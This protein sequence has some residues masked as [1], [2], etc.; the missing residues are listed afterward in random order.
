MRSLVL[1]L[2]SSRLAWGQALSTCPESI[3]TLKPTSF[4]RHR[5]LAGVFG[6][7]AL[8]AVFSL[9]STSTPAHAL[10]EA[11]PVF[12][13]AYPDAPACAAGAVACTMC[14]T[15]PPARNL[16][17]QAVEAE[18]LVGVPRPLDPDDFLAALPSAL[19]AI[20]A[21]DTDGDGSLNLEEILGGSAP[22]DDTSVPVA[23]ECDLLDPA[24]RL[25]VCGYSPRYAFDK[26]T[27]DMCGRRPTSDEIDTFDSA[28]DARDAIRAM[29]ATCVDT[30][31]WRGR[32]GV[33]WN[34]ANRKIKPLQAIKSGD[35][36]GDIPLADYNDD[37]NYFV[38]T[39][40]DDR[41]VREVLTGQYLVRG[42]YGS[43]TTYERYQATIFQEIASK[44]YEA[45]QG[46]PE[47]RRAGLLTHRWFL[48]S[49]TMFTAIPRTTAAQAY[50]AFLGSDISRL[51]GLH[52][53]ADEPVDY[54][55]KG[56]Q[57]PACARCHT[58]LDPLTYPF[59]RYE[60][61]GGGDDIEFSLQRIPY[62]YYSNRMSAFATEFPGIENTPEAGFIFGEPVADLLE[63]AQ[64]AAN[65]P[66]F[67]RATVLDYWR[68]LIG[69][70]PRG[71]DIAEFTQLWQDFGPVHNFRIESMLEALILTDAYGRP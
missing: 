42:N 16:F 57:A 51:E 58:T 59:T 34:L 36:E 27:L 63:W 1:Q 70:D 52:P 50:R 7:T 19:A 4:A 40:T 5:R 33:V 44:G 17:G 66:A 21:D 25:D 28:P 13:A 38:W 43:T 60:G 61:I 41:D 48:M 8:G 12:C 69:E 6:L 22:A 10:P 15:A 30:E 20:E 56:V 35:N 18:V 9:L 55:L 14:H 24:Q 64:V 32:N 67:A 53:I 29:M 45:A 26:V 3:M 54:D 39:Q 62:S 37:Y 68:L 31:F 49:N 11:P 47:E 65:S 2:P 23:T 46:V 71:S